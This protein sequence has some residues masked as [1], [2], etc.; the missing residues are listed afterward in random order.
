MPD[1][2]PAPALGEI[3]EVCALLRS[4]AAEWHMLESVDV[5]PTALL[6]VLDAYAAQ[7][8]RL[9]VVDDLLSEHGDYFRAVVAERDRQQRLGWNDAHDDGHDFIAW[10]SLLAKQLGD[11]AREDWQGDRD[12]PEWREAQQKA[13]VQLCAV[14]LACWES[15]QRERADRGG[16]KS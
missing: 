1:P 14:G 9:A 16:W 13:I 5:P 15:L 7:A 11:V 2:T 3:A 10:T 6:A 8:A 12:Y 4:I